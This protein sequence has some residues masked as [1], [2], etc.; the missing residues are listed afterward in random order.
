MHGRKGAG[1]P[2]VVREVITQG[3][4][5][6]TQWQGFF[7]ISSPGFKRTPL[8]LRQAAPVEPG[9]ETACHPSGQ[10]VTTQHIAWGW[11]LILESMW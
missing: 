3:E 9:A 10:E 7:S 8:S 1:S 4:W 2:L 11:I 5:A 6:A